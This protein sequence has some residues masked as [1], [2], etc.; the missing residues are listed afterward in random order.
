MDAGAIKRSS[1]D[2]GLRCTPQRYAAKALLTKHNGCERCGNVEG[3]EWYDVPKP[4]WG[5]IG[6]R[7][8]REC[9]VIFRELCAKGAPSFASR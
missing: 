9:E 5:T 1:E 8:L 2:S 3:M 6:K 4:A 7:I